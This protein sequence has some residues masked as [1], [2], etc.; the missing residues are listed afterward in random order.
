MP[1]TDAEF[2]AAQQASRRSLLETE[3]EIL[4]MARRETR[5]RGDDLDRAASRLEKKLVVVYLLGI[6]L[7]RAEAAQHALQSLLLSLPSGLS[8][9][10]LTR[11]LGSVALGPGLTT[12]MDAWRAARAARGYASS[13]LIVARR[14]RDAGVRRPAVAATRAQA[15][16]LEMGVTTENAWAAGQEKD[17]IYRDFARKNA[18]LA[19]GLLKVWDAE[20]DRRTCPTCE[21]AH[22]EMVPLHDEFS[23]GVPGGVHP[24]CRCSSH[25]VP[26]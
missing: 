24:R 7:S 6:A 26:A 16:R 4:E 12:P 1:G 19:R 2:T 11:I 3:A 23:N 17:R 18:R 5:T 22:G 20:L 10:D 8:A 13:W 25:V 14:A 15:W 9:R 21:G